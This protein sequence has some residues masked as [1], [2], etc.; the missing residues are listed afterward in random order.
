MANMGERLLRDIGLTSGLARVVMFLGH[1]SS[2]LNNPHKSAYD[3]GACTGSAG[4]PNARALAMMLNDPRVR[5]ILAQ[6]GLEIPR[7]TVFFGGLHNTATETVT[8]LD[9]DLLPK[10]HIRDYESAKETLDEVCRRYA[11]ERCRR[12]DSAP[13]DLS[14]EA[15]HQHVEGRSEDLAQTRPEFGNASNA[16]CFVGRRERIRGLFL[17]RR[18]FMN[19]YDPTQ[20]DDQHNILARIL[21]AAIPVCEGI[22][23]QYYLSYVDSPGWAC[24]T[25]LPHNITS[26][27]GVM[28]GAASDLR[29][30]LP[31]QG[32]EIHEPVRLLFIVETT[33]DGMI[34]IM[35]RNPVV[36]RILQNGWAQ[37]AV[38]SPDSGEIRIFRNGEFQLYVSESQELIEVSSSI[39][40]YRGWRNHLG[41]AF[42]NPST[43]ATPT[44]QEQ[45][46]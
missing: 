10:S 18:C 17:D 37:L 30:G 5:T 3:C 33:P 36:G 42:I 35:E 13:L 7:D 21:A 14:Y 2:C 34:Q 25:K 28:D 32:V 23:M 11:H 29:P 9:L 1:G 43:N 4:S 41:F 44:N 31:W 38:L 22:N 24:G 39:D 15:A 12:F 19:S 46:E 40:W 16:M 45:A 20:D 27:L 26:L 8:F 6:R